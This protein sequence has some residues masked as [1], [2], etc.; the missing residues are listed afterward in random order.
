LLGHNTSVVSSP[1]WGSASAGANDQFGQRLGGIMKLGQRRG[2]GGPIGPGRVNQFGPLAPGLLAQ[3]IEPLGR[4][5]QDIRVDRPIHHMGNSTLPP[6]RRHG[7]R[8]FAQSAY[9]ISLDARG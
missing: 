5:L 9:S 3:G 1:R 6:R 4:Q 8:A 2:A 7:G